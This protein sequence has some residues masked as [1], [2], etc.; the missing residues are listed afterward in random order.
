[1][2]AVAGE[3][4]SC[5]HGGYV[6][7]RLQAEVAAAGGI[8]AL[9]RLLFLDGDLAIAAVISAVRGL[10]TGPPPIK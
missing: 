1:M 7:L 6:L 5:L 9:V 10:L 2:A 3:L 4:S 8:P